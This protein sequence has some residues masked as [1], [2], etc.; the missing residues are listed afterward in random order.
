VIEIRKRESIPLIPHYYPG[1]AP[2]I[3]PFRGQTNQETENVLLYSFPISHFVVMFGGTQ[4]LSL[5]HTLPI[6]ITQNHNSNFF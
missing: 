2:E 3:I 5:L 4:S 6:P 1:F